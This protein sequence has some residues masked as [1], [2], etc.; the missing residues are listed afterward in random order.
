MT[1]RMATRW[2]SAALGLGLAACSPRLYAAPAKPQ[3]A[4]PPPSQAAV[5]LA[6]VGALYNGVTTYQGTLTQHNSGVDP[7]GKSFSITIVRTFKF[8]K[9]NYIR[10]DSTVTGARPDGK[11]KSEHEITYCD[12]KIVTSWAPEKKKYVRKPAPPQASLGE[13]LPATSGK[14][15]GQFT[16]DSSKSVDGSPV[17]IL[18]QVLPPLPPTATRA[19]IANYRSVHAPVITVTQKDYHM[20]GLALGKGTSAV[21]FRFSDQTFNGPIGNSTFS[22]VPPRGSHEIKPVAPGQPQG[23]PGSLPR[24]APNKK[25]GR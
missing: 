9:P 12:G 4:P 3:A 23:M 17:Y 11:S 7:K 6:R 13:I 22:F 2:S 20:I 8:K 14:S 24:Q 15:D 19:Q 25:P 16:V 10:I 21:S 1:F 18:Q 5:I